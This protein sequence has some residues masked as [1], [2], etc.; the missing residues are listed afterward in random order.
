MLEF[1]KSKTHFALAL[2]GT[3]FALY[4]FLQKLENV[5]FVYLDYELKASY[6]YV[7][8]AGFL[9][10][11]V[12]CFAT[13]LVSERSLSWLEK[14]GNYAYGLAIIVVPLY[15]GLYLAS[16]LAKQVG[17]SH[18]AWAA[19]L[20]I[21]AV[22]A[23]GF[24]N[25]VVFQVVSDRFQKQIGTASGLIGA[26]GGFG[27]FL[28]PS[29]LGFLKDVTGTYGSGFLLFALVCMGAWLSVALAIRGSRRKD[30]RLNDVGRF[31]D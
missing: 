20:M 19:P 1:T 5:G 18:L 24:G 27:G 22:A 7:L 28:L 12:Y 4:P 10:V 14:L 30:N 8:I 9:A 29:W 16:L 26:A 13:A 3:L 2:L 25:G 6:A 11:A 17:H 15:G 23:M 21:T 31:L